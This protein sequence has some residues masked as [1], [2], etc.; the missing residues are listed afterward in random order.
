MVRTHQYRFVVNEI[1][2]INAIFIIGRVQ[3]SGIS[4]TR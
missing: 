1:S 2:N 4:R 3:S